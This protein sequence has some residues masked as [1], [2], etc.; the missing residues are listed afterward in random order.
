MRISVLKHQPV[1]SA[2]GPVLLPAQQGAMPVS[3]VPAK[4]MHAKWW[5]WI[6]WAAVVELLFFPK[7]KQ[8]G[9][10]WWDWFVLGAALLAP[11][12]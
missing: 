8:P 7:R 2:P 10:K 11:F 3:S 1:T 4:T 5:N 6:V 12:L 9:L